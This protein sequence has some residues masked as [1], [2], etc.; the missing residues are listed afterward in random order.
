MASIDVVKQ[1]LR[2][3]PEQTAF[4]NEINELI[5]SA[6]ADLG[7]SGILDDNIVTADPLIRRAIITYCK[8]NF[9]WDNPDA[10]RLQ[11]AYDMLK[12]HMAL[13]DFAYYD[14]AFVLKDSVGSVIK[15]AKVVL[16]YS[17]DNETEREKTQ[18]TGNTGQTVF[19]VRPAT[20]YEYEI[21]ADGFQT[22]ESFFDVM[23]NVSFNLTLTEV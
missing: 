7:I 17:K 19:S 6:K 5:L 21:T 20:N 2:I 8:A 10:D 12:I 3:S 1:A 13:S 16:K 14:I 22:E 18:Y 9:G 11:K 15:Q 23:G 4:N